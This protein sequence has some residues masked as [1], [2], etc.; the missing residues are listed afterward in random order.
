MNTQ[1]SRAPHHT[2]QHTTG[3]SPKEVKIYFCGEVLFI[4]MEVNGST[5]DISAVSDFTNVTVLPPGASNLTNNKP[6][7]P[8]GF[9]WIGDKPVLIY[10]VKNR[11]VLG[12][13]RP[14][15]Y[16]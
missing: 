13:F 8:S 11:A 6:I 3:G 14:V 1:K 10:D 12:A 15:F 5:I 2:H 9:Y 4:Q 16:V 7:A